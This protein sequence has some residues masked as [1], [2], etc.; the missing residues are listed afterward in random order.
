MSTS[1]FN[2][3]IVIDNKSASKLISKINYDRINGI[4]FK[5]IDV[6]K[7]LKESAKSLKALLFR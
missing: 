2:E 5:E 1:S 7:E 6:Q 3:K 4:S